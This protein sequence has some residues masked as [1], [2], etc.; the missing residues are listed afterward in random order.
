MCEWAPRGLRKS[1]EYLFKKV[2]LSASKDNAFG[3]SQSA[4]RSSQSSDGVCALKKVKHNDGT[5]LASVEESV[6]RSDGE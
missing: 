1:R 6:G 2:G 5:S 4:S 3:L